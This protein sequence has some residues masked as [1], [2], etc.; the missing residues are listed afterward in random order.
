MLTTSNFH[1]NRLLGLCLF[2]VTAGLYAQDQVA[3]DAPRAAPQKP[4]MEQVGKP[5][6]RVGPLVLTSV[7]VRTPG[8]ILQA[9]V[10]KDFIR[11]AGDP[12]VVEVQLIDHLGDSPRSNAPVIV[13]NGKSLAN[14][15]Y[16][17]EQNVLVAFLSDSASLGATNSV[18]AIWLGAK[19]ETRSPAGLSFTLQDIER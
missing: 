11:L 6:E 10:G 1:A 3:P 4:V 5:V 9:L 18:E 17:P 15:W 19:Q 2:L 13:L 12:L 14:T 7:S 8:P 16:L